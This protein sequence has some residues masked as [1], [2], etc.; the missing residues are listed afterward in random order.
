LVNTQCY[1]RDFF[2]DK[3]RE[4]AKLAAELKLIVKM[5]QLI[6][7]GEAKPMPPLN[8]MLS[9]F[10][11]PAADFCK[12]FNDATEKW[13]EGVLLPT[14]VTKGLRAKD[15]RMKIKLP[16]STLVLFAGNDI[17]KSV[18]TDRRRS[19]MHLTYLYD[20]CRFYSIELNEPIKKISP[21]IYSTI[22]SIKVKEIYAY[23]RKK[24][25]KKIN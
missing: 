21:M 24:K 15:F 20:V 14:E 13:T 19:H 23:R 22:R 6:P 3:Q 1:F 8:V 9:Q 5:R 4:K 11:V 7:A 2:L 18:V 25:K 17:F 10:H 16:K 12:K